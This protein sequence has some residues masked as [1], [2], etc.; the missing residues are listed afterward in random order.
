MSLF[1]LTFLAIASLWIF[2]SLAVTLSLD[3]EVHTT[4]W[5]LHLLQSYDVE[6]FPETKCEYFKHMLFV[7][8]KI[9]AKAVGVGIFFVMVIFFRVATDWIAEPI[10]GKYVAR[11]LQKDYWKELITINEYDFERSDMSY[12]E[13]PFKRFSFICIVLVALLLWFAVFYV[14]Y[15]N[16]NT[17]HCTGAGFGVILVFWVLFTLLGFVALIRLAI[18]SIILGIKK[19]FT[20]AKDSDWW[21]ML[22]GKFCASLTYKD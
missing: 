16:C 9:G 20:S 4:S 21:K 22:T 19:S 8:I 10:K 14:S 15:Q 13:F 1:W 7:P 6:C 18:K 12:A 11:A 5:H 3:K 17:G 2:V